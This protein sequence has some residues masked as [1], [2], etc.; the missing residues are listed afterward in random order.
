VIDDGSGGAKT[1]FTLSRVKKWYGGN[2]VLDIPRF[3]I[4]SSRSYGLVGPNGSGKSTL[5]RI[6]ASLEDP[7]EGGIDHPDPADVTMLLQEPYLLKRSVFENVAFGLRA[8]R[9]KGR[10]LT[11]RVHDALRMVGLPPEKFGHRRGSALSGGEAQRTALAARLVLNPQVLL[12]DEPTASVDLTNAQLIRQTVNLI[13]S[14]MNTTLVVASHDVTWLHGVCDEIVRMHEGR[15][16]GS[17]DDNVIP[18]PWMRD[19][20]GLWSHRLQDGQTIRSISP[21][22]RDSRATL[23]S[24]DIVVS[25]DRP[26]HI[27]AQNV[28]SGRLVHLFAEEPTERVR[29]NVQVS[30]IALSCSVTRRA[31]S[32]LGLVPGMAVW[33]FFKASSLVWE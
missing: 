17:E 32:S 7:D 5:L 26:D 12:L 14:T 2:L 3:V 18:G 22:H 29:L 25:T 31:V 33:V 16:V 8:R 20:D 23:G 11:D 21:P 9:V 30:D 13:R 1:M 6:L 28:L 27:S 4:A 24:T 19:D 15:I 10:P